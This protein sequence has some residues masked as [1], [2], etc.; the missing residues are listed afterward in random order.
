MPVQTQA[1]GGPRMHLQATWAVV[2]IA[3]ALVAVRL[4]HLTSDT[5]S[6]FAAS[7]IGLRVDEG[8]KTLG[9]R[10]L[11]LFGN[12][13]WSPHDE[14]SGWLSGSPFTQ[15][16]LYVTFR[17]F[18]PDLL[19]ARATALAYFLALA[20]MV[21]AAYR[22]S[23]S[24]VQLLVIA[25]LLALEPF[26]FFFSRVALFEVAM[27]SFVVAGLLAVRQVGSRRPWLGVVAMTVALAAAFFLVKKSAPLYFV[28]AV[29]V[30][31]A[32]LV[33][34]HR[35]RPV[36]LASLF[37]LAGVAVLLVV[38]QEI[39]TRRVSAV[40]AGDAYRRFLA[41]PLITL[42]PWL[43]AA[44]WWCLADLIRRRGEKLLGEPYVLAVAATFVGTPLL[45]C[46]MSYAPPRYVVAIV[47]AQILMVAHWLEDRARTGPPPRRTPVATA[48]SVIPL[49][50]AIFIAGWAFAEQVLPLT[51]MPMGDE[52]GVS[53][54]TALRFLFPLAVLAA[55]VAGWLSHGRR[56]IENGLYPGAVHLLA[57]LTVIGGLGLAGSVWFSPD[58]E[59]HRIRARLAE[60]VPPE[61]AIIG[62]WAPFFALGTQ[63]PAV[64]STIGLNEGS[65]VA[66]IC[67]TYH[68]HGSA[69]DVLTARSW[70]AEAGVAAGEAIPLGRYA[71][72]DVSLRPLHYPPGVCR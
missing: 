21:L 66:G 42:S 32:H 26:L 22:R 50:V 47:P 53:T 2:V 40:S 1:R 43:S 28:P 62:D 27:G 51:G 70:E 25:G 34:R 38:G 19:V 7:D 65:A 4:P 56:V 72:R 9:P 59:S 3:L 60:L 39:W 44:A 17:L 45:L 46:F 57:G 63:I 30:L 58:Y 52:P 11:V 23:V 68:V 37:A 12:E 54:P 18:E 67:P 71:G 20:L 29:G 41:N 69:Q 15:G 24:T 64:Y 31:A 16:L 55:V 48:A 35:S 14:Y 8:Y 49:A 33:H 6:D 61:Q 10:N 13:H 36:L 5:P